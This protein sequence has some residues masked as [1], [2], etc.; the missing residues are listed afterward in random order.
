[1][2][3]LIT[4]SYP[5]GPEDWAGGFV[6]ERV[7]RLR[8]SGAV[9]EVIAAGGLVDDDRAVVR[10]PDGSLF[11]GAGAPEALEVGGA[12]WPVA[13]AFTARLVREV[14]ARAPRWQSVESHWLLPSALVACA[15]A[16]RLPHRAVS[17]GGDVA[18]L[19]RLPGGRTLARALVRAGVRL[20]FASADLQARFSRLADVASVGEVESAPL[21]P[22][23]FHARPPAE[24][25]RLRGELGCS[26]P[27][28]LGVGRLV[29]IKGWE[30]LVRAVARLPRRRRPAV[31]L[32]GDGPQ[33]PGLAAQAARAG[34]TLRLM[35]AVNRGTVA[36]WMAAA[37]LYVQPSVRLPNGRAEGMPLAVREALAAGVPVIASAVGGLGELAHRDLTL[38]PPAQPDALARAIAAFL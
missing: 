36:N 4:T 38:V 37:D 8:A 25:D 16:P 1:M 35:G 15:V 19:E 23:L 28:V 2:I 22:T 20:V 26:G 32:L 24:R 34:I 11:E 31:V 29:P 17:H 13:L 12:A 10:V 9:V 6:R 3:G 7:R 18:L 30:V 5:R 33:G 27:T 21:D 14:A